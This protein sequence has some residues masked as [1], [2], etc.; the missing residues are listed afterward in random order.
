[1][2]SPYVKNKTKHRA[3]VQRGEDTVSH[4]TAVLRAGVMYIFLIAVMRLGGK[5]QIG[6]LQLSELVTALLLSEIATT[7][8][9]SPELSLPSA[10]LPILA[11]M[12]LEIL[13]T[14]ATAKSQRLKRL[15][16]G[17]PS[18]VIKRGELNEKEMGRLRMS[19]EELIAECRQA[20][21]RDLADVGYAVLEENGRFSIFEKAA[22]GETER[23]IAHAL[24]VDGTISQNGLKLAGYTEKKLLGEIRKRKLELAQIFLYTVND[25]GEE[26]LIIK[27]R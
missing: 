4:L 22:P 13:V 10:M 3:S 15:F 8:I 2:L 23:G 26:H 11:V 16:D 24:I 18:V 14:Y 21:I 27:S 19:V 9:V 20:G 17:T 6:E 5:R 25:A 7:P 12:S 1:M